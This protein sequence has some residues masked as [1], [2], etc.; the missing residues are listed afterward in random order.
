M[1]YD[2]FHL[3]TNPEL[4]NND[5]FPIKTLILKNT[6]LHISIGRNNRNVLLHTHI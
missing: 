6:Y 3:P 2:Y 4:I 1:G 5:T